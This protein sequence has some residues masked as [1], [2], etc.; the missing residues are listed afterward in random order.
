MYIQG[1]YD[2]RWNNDVLNPAFASLHAADFEVVQLGWQPSGPPPGSPCTPDDLT[3]CLN[4]GRFAV[5]AAWTT[6][7]GHTGAG[8]AVALT[9][10]TGFFWFFT[11]TNVEVVVKVLA[12]CATNGHY[13]VFAGG[14]TNTRVRLSVRDAQIDAV[15]QYDN[16][17][18]TAFQPV[19]DTRA[20]ATCP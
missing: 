8:H 14:L 10:D 16:P 18:G 15:R 13:W 4:D 6:P 2:T 17:Q 7:D 5:T 12:G 11:P 19:Q 1:T 3:L 9:A 20:F